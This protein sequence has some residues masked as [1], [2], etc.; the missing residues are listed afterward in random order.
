MSR[1]RTRR[2]RHWHKW[3]TS[4]FRKASTMDDDPFGTAVWA[5][6]EAT[7]I[8]PPKPQSEASESPT[9]DFDDFTST[10]EFPAADDDFA[11]FADFGE[12]D[13]SIEEKLSTDLA[14]LYR[15]N[16]DSNPLHIDKEFAETA[17]FPSPILHGLCTFGIAVKHVMKA[18]C[19]GDPDAVKSMKVSRS[20]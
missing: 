15:L 20:K 4:E 7:F 2:A 11:D 8:G 13:A 5:S 19:N 18:F 3:L 12:A 6:S 16:G 17:G 9:N 1:S 14:A 10:A